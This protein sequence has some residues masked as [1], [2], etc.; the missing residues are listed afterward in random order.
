[1]MLP[2]LLFAP[3]IPLWA[4]AALAL[5]GLALTVLAARGRGWAAW[6]RLL[7]LA[8]VLLALANPRLTQ[9]QATDLDDVALVLVDESAS[10]NVSGRHEQAEAA[11][12]GVVD[13][14][15]RLAG[16]EV[17]VE[18]YRPAP[19]RDEGTQLFHALDRALAD[20]PRSRLA[21]TIM[22]TD[23]EVHDVPAKLD[24]SAPLHALIVGH[25][26]ER[27]RRLVIDQAPAFGIVGNTAALSFHVE[28]PGFDGA[29]TVTIRRDAGTPSTFPVQLNQP[30]NIDIPLDH[31][32]ANVVE[33]SVEA[34]PNELTLANNR[35]AVVVSGVRD[36]LRVL[37]ISGEPHAGERVWRNLLKADP[38]VDLVHFTILR[39]PEK[40]D[41]TPLRDLALIAF[42][43]RE[44]FE[45][46]LKDFDLIILDRFRR[47]A[48]LPPNYYNNIG[49]YVRNGGALL[50][51]AGPEFGGMDSPFPTA[52][53]QVLPAAPTGQNFEHPFVPL[54]TDLGKRHPV[55]A[56]LPGSEFRSAPLGPL[57]A[58]DRQHPARD[59]HGADDRARRRAALGAQPG[60]A[61]ARGRIAD[62]HLVAVVARLRR[63]RAPGRAA[64][65]A[66]PLDD[67]GA[68]AGGGSA[69]RRVAR[70][71][72]LGAA[73]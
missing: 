69:H 27:D 48:V 25:K 50:V 14:L 21:G 2:R 10:M 22:I 8:V 52:L 61:G 31:A 41:A 11:L 16:L 71:H 40:D 6:W 26:N 20:V 35:A 23:G 32:G 47:R 5:A 19:G 1:M 49:N 59:R 68:R 45:E 13:Q 53:N 4:L 55:T 72:A 12:A 46:K 57:D 54:L 73:P 3:W 44:L 9:A 37:L 66:G 64:A 67:E 38:S 18:R 43:V 34:A 65:P 15:K 39:P 29:A 60:R 28:D 24:A 36:R 51:A 63:R 58:R 30:S 7:P 17:R 42:P 56:D 70:R 33:L 62:R